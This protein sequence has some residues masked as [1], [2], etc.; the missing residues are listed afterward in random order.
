M[1]NVHSTLLRGALGDIFWSL[2][3]GINYAVGAEI[4]VI[5]YV[6]NNDTVVHDYLIQTVLSQGNRVVQTSY[7]NVDNSLIFTVNPGEVATL[8]GS[9]K[10]PVSG[11]T[12]QVQLTERATGTIVDSV[13]TGLVNSGSIPFLPGGSSTG[14]TDIFSTLMSFMMLMMMVKM[15]GETMEPKDEA[16]K[17]LKTKKEANI[18]ITKPKPLALAVQQKLQS[19]KL[20]TQGSKI[21]V[22]ARLAEW[23]ASQKETP[24]T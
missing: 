1:D 18:S 8:P 12:L 15:M 22:Q 6:A 11:V 23:D 24:A 19:N 2:P 3:S 13:S 17:E 21:S 4:P 14:T 9:L 16:N 20:L 5:I 7:I 10:F